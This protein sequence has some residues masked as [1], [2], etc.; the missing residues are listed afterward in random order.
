MKIIETYIV[1]YNGNYRKLHYCKNT[2][3]TYQTYYIEK[4]ETII[5]LS[6]S[7]AHQLILESTE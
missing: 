7:Q 3:G 6:I 1:W 4:E 2:V 5:E